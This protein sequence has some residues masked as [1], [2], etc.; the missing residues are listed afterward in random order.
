MNTN[1]EVDRRDGQRT[2]LPE[3]DVV[4]D[5]AMGARTEGTQRGVAPGTSRR[6]HTAPGVER[7]SVDPMR[8]TDRYRLVMPY[9]AR[10]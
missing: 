8:T 7:V 9:T 4:H 2:A 10:V 1:T 5:E 6:R 3:L